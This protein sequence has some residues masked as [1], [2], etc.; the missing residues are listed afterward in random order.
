MLAGLP[1]EPV[2]DPEEPYT[3]PAGDSYEDP[4]ADSAE[5]TA[6]TETAKGDYSEETAFAETVGEWQTADSQ[7]DAAALAGIEFY[8]A[9][10]SLVP[11]GVD[12]YVEYQYR[13]GAARAIFG[14]EEQDF[15]LVIE[16]ARLA[17]TEEGDV[18]DNTFYSEG[19]DDYTESMVH[20]AGGSGNTYS[21]SF[22]MGGYLYDIA[23]AWG[24]DGAGLTNDELAGLINALYGIE[25]PEQ[26]DTDAEPEDTEE[27]D[28]D[29]TGEA[30]SPE[31]PESRQE[32][33]LAGD[34]ITAGEQVPTG[35]QLPAGEQVSTIEQVSAGETALAE[36][37]AQTE[38]AEPTADTVPETLQDYA[39]ETPQDYDGTGEYAGEYAEGT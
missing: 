13:N 38:Y 21:V 16:K 28:T 10:W 18:Q 26:E 23:Y 12:P 11:D 2:P 4:G 5:E 25:I 31:D 30:T 37:S 22:E 27:S 34:Q 15:S 14:D 1:E 3:E 35:E 20:Y 9:V 24:E 6:P 33:A 19:A 17:M 8:D 36:G 32:G 39:G 7:E 29:S